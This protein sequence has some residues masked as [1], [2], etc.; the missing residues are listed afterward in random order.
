MKIFEE[1][2]F[3]QKQCSNRAP[4]EG[5]CMVCSSNSQK[6]GEKSECIEHL[7]RDELRAGKEPLMSC[8]VGILL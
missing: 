3:R 4:K 1:E 6:S 8:R 2:W 7:G 5:V